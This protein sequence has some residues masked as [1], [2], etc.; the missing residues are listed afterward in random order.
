AAIDVP[1]TRYFLLLSFKYFF[2][3]APAME[4]LFLSLGSYY[5][6][7]LSRTRLVS[8][9]TT[10]VGQIFPVANIGLEYYIRGGWGV[11]IEG[12]YEALSLR[13]RFN[14]GEVQDTSEISY[15]FGAGLSIF[16]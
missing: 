6:I 10:G 11:H 16:F 12:G 15:R 5:G 13:E 3:P 4:N 9:A 8:E 14:D 2:V 7:G 1:S